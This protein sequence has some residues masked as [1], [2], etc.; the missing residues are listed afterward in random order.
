MT[1]SLDNLSG[2][3]EP[4]LSK[5]YIYKIFANVQSTCLKVH[6]VIEA[7]LWGKMLLNL[8]IIFVKFKVFLVN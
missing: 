5:W 1:T 8:S 2:Y 7:I 4:R 3:G 6:E